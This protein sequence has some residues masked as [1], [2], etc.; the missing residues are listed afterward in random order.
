MKEF[1][2]IQSLILLKIIITI[3]NQYKITAKINLLI[4][5]LLSIIVKIKTATKEVLLPLMLTMEM[6]M[7]QG[8]HKE[9]RSLM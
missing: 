6:V 3:I 7:A 9:M 2:I 8:L 1:L 5:K 4:W